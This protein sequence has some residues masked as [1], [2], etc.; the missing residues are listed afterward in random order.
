LEDRTLVPVEGRRLIV[1]RVG[2]LHFRYQS[3]TGELTD[4]KNILKGIPDV[5]TV[6]GNFFGVYRRG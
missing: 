1:P 5:L 3:P 2:E 6:V 4:T